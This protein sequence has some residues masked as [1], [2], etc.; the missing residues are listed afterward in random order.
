MPQAHPLTTQLRD[1]ADEALDYTTEAVRDERITRIEIARILGYKRRLAAG[2][3]LVDDTFHIGLTGLKGGF[4]TEKIGKRVRQ[5]RRLHGDVVD[6][7]A[8]RTE[9]RRE[10]GTPPDAA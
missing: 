5:Q 9:K 2:L 3:A 8:Y 7:T 6:L 4:H 1:L 10:G